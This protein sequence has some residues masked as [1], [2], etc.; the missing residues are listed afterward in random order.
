MDEIDSA[1]DVSYDDAFNDGLFATSLNN[2][3]LTRPKLWPSSVSEMRG[4]TS[5]ATAPQLNHLDTG[6]SSFMMQRAGSAEHVGAWHYIPA[7]QSWVWV[8]GL[9]GGMP[10]GLRSM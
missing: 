9:P 5:F 4:H 3:S 6:H 1:A 8:S 7:R 2:S 10:T